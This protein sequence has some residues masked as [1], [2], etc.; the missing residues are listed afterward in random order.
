MEKQLNN[1]WDVVSAC[2]ALE[3]LECPNVYIL[4]KLGLGALIRCLEVNN[5]EGL[6]YKQPVDIIKVQ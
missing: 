4:R 3:V 1:E 6:N 2:E 5:I